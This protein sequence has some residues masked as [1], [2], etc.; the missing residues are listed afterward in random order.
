MVAFNTRAPLDL[1]RI[2]FCLVAV[3]AGAWLVILPFWADHK[4]RQ[5]Q[6]GAAE[7]PAWVAAECRGPDGQPMQLLIH[8]R[9]PVCF[10]K[11]TT[12]ESGKP[13]FS[14][15]GPDGG[16][17][18]QVDELDRLLREAEEFHRRLKSMPRA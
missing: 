14:A 6:A 12:D 16:V 17:T 7:L 5:R 2:L 10:V 15:A 1:P 3:G 18:L 4:A 9:A 8:A 13:A 11:V